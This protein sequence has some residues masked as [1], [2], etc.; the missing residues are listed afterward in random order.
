MTSCT[1]IPCT[2]LL[3]P[4][5]LPLQPP[6]IFTP[7]AFAAAALYVLY[8]QWMTGGSWYLTFALPVIVGLT[9]IVTAVVSGIGLLIYNA[10]LTRR[11]KK[12]QNEEENQKES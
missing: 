1:G 4:C 11:Q 6:V 3:M 7:C 10:I 2:S 5:R 8:I 12:H 9:L